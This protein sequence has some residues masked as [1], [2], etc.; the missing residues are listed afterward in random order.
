[1]TTFLKNLQ[2]NNVIIIKPH[3][4][5]NRFIQNCIRYKHTFK[6]VSSYIEERICEFDPII[7]QRRIN[8]VNE[9][10]EKISTLFSNVKLFDFNDL[11]CKNESCN[12]YNKK[13]NLIYFTDNTHI[14]LEFAEVISQYFEIWFR[15]EQFRYN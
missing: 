4:R 13:N 8:V 5:T 2:G 14:T 10:L 3:Q 12:L 6:I 15:N 9:K 7:D 1:M 11:I